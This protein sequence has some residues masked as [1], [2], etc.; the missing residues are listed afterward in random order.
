MLFPISTLSTLIF[1][2]FE[3]DGIIT[4]SIY[5]NILNIDTHFIVSLISAGDKYDELIKRIDE[6][7]KNIHF[8]ELEF[9][10]K[11]KVFISN[12]IFSYE[13]V[14]MINDMI[15]DNIIFDGKIETNIIGIIRS[16]NMN[17]LKSI[18]RKIDFNNKSIVIQKK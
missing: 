11:K 15:V 5:Y 12:E 13:N 6:K 3:N 9:E 14:E 8:D 16:L 1:A 10:R 18:V 7:F 17:E 4:N 2:A